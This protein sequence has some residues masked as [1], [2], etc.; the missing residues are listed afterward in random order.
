M[1]RLRVGDAVQDGLIQPNDFLIGDDFS[2]QTLL[3]TSLL[4]LSCIFSDYGRKRSS[5]LTMSSSSR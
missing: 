3:P 1:P 2:L 5:N 4:G